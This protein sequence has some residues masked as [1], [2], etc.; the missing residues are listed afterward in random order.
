MPLGL[1]LALSLA[2]SPACADPAL[3]GPACALHVVVPDLQMGA[4]PD[5][6]TPYKVISAKWTKGLIVGTAAVWLVWDLL[7]NPTESSILRD[8]GRRSVALPWTV[9]M[10]AGH[11]FWPADTLP[12]PQSV[13]W[14]WTMNFT[15]LAVLV[16]WDVLAPGLL[17]GLRHP[18]LWVPLGYL[19]GHFLWGQPP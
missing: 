17:P 4:R 15:V 18:G 14:R 16:A 1:L 3:A 10:L 12:A 19:C 2:L 9:G 11:W 8:W 13:R 7:A 5:A 6:L